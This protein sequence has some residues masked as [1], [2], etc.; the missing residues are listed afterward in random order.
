VVVASHH[1]G[2][3]ASAVEDA[4]GTAL[5]LAQ[6]RYW[7]GVP[8][9]QRP[10][11]MMFLLTSGHMAGAAGTKAFIDR[12]RDLLPR[13][14]L[15]IHLEH[16]ARHCEVKDG[17]LVPTGIPEPRWWFTTC[18]DRL[19]SIV[20]DA[21]RAE[22]L[23]RSLVLPPDVFFDNPPTDGSAFHAEGVPIVQFLTAPMYL[24]DS[25]DTIDKVH[26]DTLVPLT[27]A[28]AGIIGATRGAIADSFRSERTGG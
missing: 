17:R 26:T 2:P 12:H 25:G 13:I 11:N 1:D 7:S 21:I 27:R 3:W 8:E 23:R 5:V 22:D 9:H 18:H 14:V 10:H 15:E 4:S 16:A 28:V 24:F 6:A 20:A 19:E